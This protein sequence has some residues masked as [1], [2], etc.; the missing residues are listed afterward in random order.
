[1]GKTY[2]VL[3]FA[4][5]Q[6]KNHVHVDFSANKDVAALFDHSIAPKELVPQL[7]VSLKTKIDPADTLIFFD[8]VQ[9]CPR[10]L[11]SLKY[12]CEQAP[13]Y[14]V[15]AAGSLLGVAL[16]REAYSYPVGKV[17]V[18]SLHPLDFEE[19]L[20]AAEE[21]ELVGLI[22]QSYLADKALGLH[23]YALRLL[24]NYLFCGGMPEVVNTA[25]NDPSADPKGIRRIQR[26]I[27]DAYL[28]DM[29]KYASS[30]DTA[31]IL[32][33]WR[34]IPEQLAKENHKFQYRMIASAARAHQY[35]APINWLKA[36]GLVEFCYR[37]SEGKAPLRAFMEQGSFKLYL[38]DTGL[39]TSLYDAEPADLEPA[40]DKGSRFRGGISENLVMQQLMAKGIESFYWGI[41]SK[42]EVE[43][44]IRSASGAVMP[45][46][47]KPGKNVTARSLEAYRRAYR[48]EYVIRCSAKN[49]GFESHAKSVPLYAA[50]CIE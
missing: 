50:F 3:E 12:F 15:I 30:A 34:G 31:K 13:E 22:R 28:A 25:L 40:N 42:S 47:V 26:L 43:F 4:R 32:N 49:F 44:V 24:R 16:G 38:L 19:Y 6:F 37:V 2:S 20:W 10:A 18:I 23:G 41:P 14:H 46:E 45:I 29:T 1:V 9:A 36:A 48:P 11:T 33:V 7:Q 35:E 39:L 21:Q 17:D 5:T 8:E 27:T